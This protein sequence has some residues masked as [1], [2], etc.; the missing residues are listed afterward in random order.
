MFCEL[1]AALLAFWTAARTASELKAIGG[2]DDSASAFV[3]SR[4][5][6]VN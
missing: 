1:D 2:R 4:T 3:K 5:Q 6:S